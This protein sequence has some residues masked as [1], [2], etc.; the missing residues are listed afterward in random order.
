MDIPTLLG[1]SA[2]ARLLFACAII[3]VLWMAVRWAALLP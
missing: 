3:A 1:R 2:I